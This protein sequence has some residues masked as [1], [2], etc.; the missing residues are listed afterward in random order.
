MDDAARTYTLA[1]LETWS[2]I[3]SG[4]SLAVLGHPIGHSISPQ[5]HNSALAKLA[6]RDARFS[7][8]RYFR[9]DL[10]PEELPRALPCFMKAGFVGLNLTLPHKIKALECADIVVGMEARGVGAV[11]TL[12]VEDGVW[13]GYNT[14]GYGLSEG[15]REDLHITLEGSHVIL[16]GAGGAARSAAVASLLRNVASLGIG[17][18]TPANLESLVSHLSRLDAYNL[19]ASKRVYTFNP[20]ALE[21]TRFPSCAIVVNATSAGLKA[22]DPLPVDLGGLPAPR[23]VYDMIYNPAET[24]LLAAARQR[25]I[26]TANGLSMLVHQ[27][28]R[29]LEIWTGGAVPVDAMSRAAR[30]A[31]GRT[32]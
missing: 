21:L 7:S 27:G 31:M 3:H 9:F 13:I 22:E 10:K 5:M 16:I 2:R 19:A 4:T 23:A 32:V 30:A 17:N 29:A 6:E 26:P 11:N 8:W 20:M 14:D 18:R 25:G 24:A 28:A 12:H 1:D 15:M